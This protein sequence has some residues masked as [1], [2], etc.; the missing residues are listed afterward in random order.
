VVRDDED[1]PV[2]VT[3]MGPIVTA[4]D[5]LPAVAL[6]GVIVANE[7][8]DNLPFRI[9]ERRDGRWSEVRVIADGDTLL[10][11]LVPATPDLAAEADLVAA[12]A[13]D[14]ARVPVPTALADWFHACASALRSGRVVLIDYVADGAELAARGEQGWLRTYRGHERGGAPLVTPGEQDITIDVPYEYLVHAASRAGF[15]L[16]RDLTQAEWL[17]E[18]G[19]A[20]LVAEARQRWD[21]RAHVG[22]LEA[23]RQRSRVSEAAAL[24]DPAGL[25]VHRVLVF[26]R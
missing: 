5:D 25:G 24:V 1:A 7:L 16:E 14:G 10:D 13:P 6:D 17:A 11:T 3:G 23:I 22:D 20:E 15:H 26:T 9:V 2:L 4:L 12:D 18:L 21:A 8:L 19:V